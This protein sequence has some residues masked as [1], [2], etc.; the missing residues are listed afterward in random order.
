MH[1]SLDVSDGLLGDLK[2][3]L[4]AS[5]VDGLIR[6]KD[7]PLSPPAHQVLTC[8]HSML[9]DLLTGGDD[10]EI[11]GTVAPDKWEGFKKKCHAAHLRI[12]SIGQVIE[13]GEGKLSIENGR[14]NPFRWDPHWNEGPLS[15]EHK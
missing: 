11:L 8:D 9:R 6:L 14:E 4:S 15:Y 10:Y 2:K 5:G 3:L 13:T 1:A 12:T 7:L